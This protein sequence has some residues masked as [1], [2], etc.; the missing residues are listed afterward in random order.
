[1]HPA[2]I[3]RARLPSRPGVDRPVSSAPLLPV[4]TSCSPDGLA[5]GMQR[6]MSGGSFV[7][8]THSE[9]TRAVV[10]IRSRLSTLM[11]IALAAV[12]VGA[13]GG[14]VDHDDDNPEISDLDS[15]DQALS[16]PETGERRDADDDDDDDRGEGHDCRDGDRDHKHHHHHMFKVLD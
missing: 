12:P 10:L 13:C 4:T 6:A 14:A 15:T 9:P 3:Y 1:P 11:V 2:I 8:S 5:G 16:G 7:L